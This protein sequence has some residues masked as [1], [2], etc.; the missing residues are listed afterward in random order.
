MSEK[1]DPVQDLLAKRDPSLDVLPSLQE[2]FQ[3]TNLT[4]LMAWS[5][6]VVRS[7]LAPKNMTE[8][9]VVLCVQ[10]AAELG[11]NPAQAIQ[12]IAVINGR[13]SIWGDLGK[14]LF[15]R[16]AEVE[17]FEERSPSDA[18]KAGAG[19]C[20]ITL[21]DGSVVERTFSVEDAKA[22]NLLDKPGPWQQY[23]GRMLQMR[24][25]WFAMRD[26]AP[27]V[28]KGVS[29]REEQED[30]HPAE[31]LGV[32]TLQRPR[33]KSAGVDERQVN[34]FL[35]Q[36]P[37]SAAP[38][39]TTTSPA[40]AKSEPRTENGDKP[41]EGSWT[42][43]IERVEEKRG[44]YQSGTR[45]GQGYVMYVLHGEGGWKGATFDSAHADVAAGCRT[46]PAHITYINGD[47]GPKVKSIEPHIDGEDEEQMP[48]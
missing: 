5:K 9:G 37:S 2:R 7:G 16:D 20:R 45:K 35:R 31:V 44:T 41:S 33:A 19:W 46:V 27:G 47:H 1:P 4:E 39:P 10:M 13:P 14:A 43:T 11:I 26:A 36:Q 30:I 25:R 21:R 8:A 34:D 15:L 29:S 18:L 22:A 42:G 17:S 23:R 6:L 48:C 32:T 28:F 12:N 24:A 3:P 38:A 40:P